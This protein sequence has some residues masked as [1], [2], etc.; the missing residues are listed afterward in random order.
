MIGD[1]TQDEL[2]KILEAHQM[3]IT[4]DDIRKAAQRVRDMDDDI[5]N[6]RAV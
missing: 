2:D 1:M 6:I 3:K 5:C 4:A